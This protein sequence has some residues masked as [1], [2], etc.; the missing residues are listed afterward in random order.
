MQLGT[1]FPPL[2]FMPACSYPLQHGSSFFFGAAFFGA[3][4]FEAAFLVVAFFAAF[5]GAAFFAVAIIIFLA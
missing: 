3:A 5:L 1:F 4:F 2:V